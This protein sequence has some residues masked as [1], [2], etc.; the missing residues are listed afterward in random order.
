MKRKWKVLT[1]TGIL[2]VTC[3]LYTWGIPAVVNIKSHKSF[4]EQKVFENSGF[5]V[6]IGNPELSMGIFPSVWVKSDN[7]SILN[8]DGTKALSID[9]PQLKIKLFQSP[10]EPKVEP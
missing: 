8:S 4:I 9:N 5:I 2:A 10:L 7:I 6:D 3:G 1:L